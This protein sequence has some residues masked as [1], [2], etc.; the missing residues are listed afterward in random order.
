MPLASA[1]VVNSAFPI[2]LRVSHF[3][4][5]FFMAFIIRAGVQI[6]A[7]HPRLYWHCDCTPGSDWFRFQKPVPTG[8]VWTAKDDSVTISGWLGIPGIAAEEAERLDTGNPHLRSMNAVIG[9]H[10]QATDGMIGHVENFMIDPAAGEI[11]Y[12]IVATKNW[13]FGQ[14]V[15]LSLYAVRDISWSDQ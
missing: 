12:L 15:L 3:P 2:W 9:Y 14:H 7:D 8:R 1:H 4:N 10:V 13:W 6:L 11:R 5:L